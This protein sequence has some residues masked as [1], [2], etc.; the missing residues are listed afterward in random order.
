MTSKYAN[1]ALKSCYEI[2][3]QR[4]DEARSDAINRFVQSKQPVK[5]DIGPLLIPCLV[6]AWA[7]LGMINGGWL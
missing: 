1:P 4:E 3:K 2:R 6:L 7:M 5:I